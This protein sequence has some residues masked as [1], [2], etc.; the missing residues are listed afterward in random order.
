MWRDVGLAGLSGNAL[1]LGEALPSGPERGSLNLP[2]S[3]ESPGNLGS[4]HLLCAFHPVTAPFGMEEYKSLFI[5][6]LLCLC[7]VY[8]FPSFWGKEDCVSF[9]S[10]LY[11]WSVSTFVLLVP[12]TATKPSEP[13]QGSQIWL[14]RMRAMYKHTH[15]HKNCETALYFFHSTES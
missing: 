2:G 9:L 11:F 6:A 15:A 3:A 13:S 12:E 4:G 8:F 14:R 7:L 1:L 5:S 10:L